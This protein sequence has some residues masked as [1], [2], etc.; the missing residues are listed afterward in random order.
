MRSLIVY[1][2]ILLMPPLLTTG[3]AKGPPPDF[4]M[5]APQAPV[6]LP[7]FESGIAIG[8]GPVE[9]PP[10][11]DRNQIV[12]RITP[13]R[14]RLSEQHHWAEPLKVG[15]TRVLLISLGLEL[16]SNRVYAL[17]TRRR[18]DLDFQVTVDV[19]RFDGEISEQVELVA[20]WNLLD[21]DGKKILLSRV[22]Q[23]NETSDGLDHEAFVA[24]QSRAVASLGRE[25]AAVII[26]R[27]R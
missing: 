24:A 7:S 18:R 3:C 15:F 14:L 20:R 4:Y 1:L 12:S 8:V 23:I 10:H 22:A 19:L 27:Q 13:N 9:L 2:L 26:E 5:L 16:D 6:N 21:S 17:P 11:L 25:I